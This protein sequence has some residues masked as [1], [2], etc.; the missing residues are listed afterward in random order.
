MAPPPHLQTN[1]PNLK[2]VVS[3]YFVL[4][5]LQ[6]WS[7]VLHDG[8]ALITG[9]MEVIPTRPSFVIMLFAF[10]VHKIQLIN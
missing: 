4:E 5:S 1:H 2:L 10:K 6:G 7:G 9:Q 8:P 3:G